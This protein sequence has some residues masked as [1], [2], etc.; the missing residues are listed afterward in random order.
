MSEAGKYRSILMFGPP[1]SGKGTQ[2]RILG[3]LPGFFHL[4]SGDMFR[5]MDPNSELGKIFLEHSTQGKLVPDDLTVRL[6][7][8]HTA[9]LVSSRQ[10]S[11]ATDVL[12]LDGIPRSR[13]Q[14][15]MLDSHIEVLLLIHM[16]ASDEN[17]LVQRMRKRA[18][19]AH[20]LDDANEEV[21][22][23]RFREYA[24]ET[25]PVLQ[26]YPAELIR[27]V[28]AASTPLDVLRQ[29]VNVIQEMMRHLKMPA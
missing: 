12:I 9:H 26:Y 18:L 20:R 15:E 19:Q 6:W 4:S 8:E 11:P 10:L 3:D 1:G 24:A 28:D 14:A 25:E 21:I 17:A 2:G 27:I 13:A 7:K 29:V 5:G 22:R 23:R 16:E